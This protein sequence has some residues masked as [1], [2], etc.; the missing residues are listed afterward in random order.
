MKRF[1]ER[2]YAY[3]ETGDALREMF[4]GGQKFTVE[5]LSKRLGLRVLDLDPLY[6]EIHQNL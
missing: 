2:A 3:P 1:G 4:A 5:E 6:E